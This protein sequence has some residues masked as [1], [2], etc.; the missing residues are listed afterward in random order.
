MTHISDHT[1]RYILLQVDGVIR[2]LDFYERPDSFI[3]VMERPEQSKDL[4][5]VITDRKFLE[6]ELARNF[7]KQVCGNI[8]EIKSPLP[9][10]YP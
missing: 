7:F 8:L 5:D 9:S 3:Y 6:E 2:L 4:F 10:F 1:F